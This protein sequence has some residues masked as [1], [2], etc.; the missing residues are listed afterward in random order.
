MGNLVNKRAKIKEYIYG[1]TLPLIDG[2]G[3]Y[4]TSLKLISRE[5]TDITELRDH[6]LPACFLLGDA[7]TNFY[8]LTAEEY[9][10]GTTEAD[11][12]NGMPLFIVG[13]IKHKR[14]ETMDKAG[15][16]ENALDDLYADITLA[17][18]GDDL[19]KG[20]Y[21]E[22]T[23]LRGMTSSIQWSESHG[24]GILVMEFSMKY[25]FNPRATNP[26]V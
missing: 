16:M 12:T 18:C 8:H 21:A 2:S 10:T 1:T 26:S 3:N 23:I 19:R 13:V 25:R 15:E 17:M 24:Y 22:A 9:V 6:D 11:L 14:K 4:T 20:G 5:F 7:P